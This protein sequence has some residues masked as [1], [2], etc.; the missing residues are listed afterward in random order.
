MPADE[1]VELKFLSDPETWQSLQ[2]QP[3]FGDLPRD[4]QQF[5]RTRYFDTPDFKLRQNGIHFRVRQ[6]GDALLQSV[7]QIGGIA[8]GEWENEL[9]EPLPNPE[10]LSG[11][12]VA[13]ILKNKALLD[14]LQPIFE[15][16]INRLS[17]LWR[18]EGVAI[19][20]CF[21]KG[22]IKANDN[23][24]HLREIELE[25]KEGAISELFAF[26]QR[27]VASAPMTLSFVSKGD[28]GF[29]LS[30]GKWGQ[31]QKVVIPRLSRDIGAGTA[32]KRICHACLHAFMLN[33]S[34]FDVTTTDIEI[35]HQS[36]V[37]LRRLRAA[38][39]FF[40][41][42]AEGQR[43]ETLRHELAW[44]SDLLGAAR[45]LDVWQSDTFRPKAAQE[46][47]HPGFAFLAHHMEGLRLQ[48]YAELAEGLASERWRRTLLECAIWLQLENWKLAERATPLADFLDTRLTDRIA[49]ILKEG[50]K[51]D[52]MDEPTKHQLRIRAKKLRY[53]MEFFEGCAEGSKARKNFKRLVEACETMQEAL[54]EI[55]DRVALEA[56]LAA[57][58]TKI[59]AQSASP[60]L[61]PA[62]F[63]AGLLA[64]ERPDHTKPLRDA[65]RA[66]EKLKGWQAF[67]R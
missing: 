23:E 52:A 17:L 56:F 12:Q 33:T 43:Y 9:S 24:L 42:I 40:A 47:E 65:H 28:R 36:R 61:V 15:T 14:Q 45:D 39:S 25:L 67:W 6:S 30:E 22:E 58:Y 64:R 34:L 54:G 19:E 63:A 31:P 3:P 8:R 5:V 46:D 35:V 10:L 53:T 62:A 18:R 16:N 49:R 7:K 21:D 66:Y 27:L 26:A 38:M 48:A 60:Q 55:H 51:L 2:T 4:G 50:H 11:R 59:D 44:M 32:F 20:I 1:E 29:L 57:E 13:P 41:P 37:A